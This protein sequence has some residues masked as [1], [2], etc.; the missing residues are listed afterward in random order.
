MKICPRF[1]CEWKQLFIKCNWY[2]CTL[3]LS[4]WSFFT[5]GDDASCGEFFKRLDMEPFE[6][7]RSRLELSF[8]VLGFVFGAEIKFERKKK[9]GEPE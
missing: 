9:K 3:F 4:E 6:L 5:Y 7:P 2:D 1:E 8:G